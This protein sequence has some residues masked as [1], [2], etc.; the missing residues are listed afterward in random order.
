[1]KYVSRLGSHGPLL[2]HALVVMYGAEFQVDGSPRNQCIARLTGGRM[3]IP[4]AGNVLVLRQ[5]GRL[6]SE[7]YESATIDDV[8]P[9]SRFFEEH[10]DFVPYA[11]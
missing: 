5:K 4:W 2:D 8:A 9:M 1:M 7:T 3:S 6:H 11:F 10:E